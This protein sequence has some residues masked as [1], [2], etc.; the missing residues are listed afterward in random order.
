MSVAAV[1]LTGLLFVLSLI[2]FAFNTDWH[3]REGCAALLFCLL[4]EAGVLLGLTGLAL[5]VAAVCL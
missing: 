5:L 1:V 3:T 2:V 4:I